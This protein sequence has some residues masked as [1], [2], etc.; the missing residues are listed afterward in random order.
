LQAQEGFKVFSESSDHEISY[1]RRRFVANFAKLGLSSTLLPGV[2]WARLRESKLVTAN[3]DMVKD[4]ARLAGLE[5]TD[6]DYKLIAEDVNKNLSR[7]M[8]MRQTHLDNSVPPPLYFNPVV[9]GMTIDRTKL[10]MR[11]SSTPKVQRPNDLEE[12]AFWPVT[13]L[14]ELI[15]TG[16]VRSTELTEMY[17]RRLRRLNPK[18]NCVVTLTDELARGEARQADAEIAAGRYRGPLHG[19]PYGV[20]D[21]IAAKGYPTTWG[22]APFKNQYFDY[23]ATVID[24]LTAAGAVL[25]AKLSTGELALGD[26][27]FGG[28]TNNPWDP[29]QGSSGSS[30]GSGA[31][32]AAGLV[33]FALGTDTGGSILSPSIVCGIVGLRPTFGRVSRYGVMAAGFSL[34]KVGVMSRTVEDC[35]IVLDVIVGAD[36]KD[37]A[38]PYDV[39]FNWDGTRSIASLRVGFFAAG[40]GREKDADTRTNGLRAIDTLRSLGIEPRP[41]DLPEN[42]VNYFI[43]YAER[44]AG[45]DEFT[46]SDG[47]DLLGVQRIRA[48]HRFARLVPAVEYLQANR[49]RM[50]VM[51]QVAK[52]MSDLDVIVAPF[53]AINQLTASTG[54]PV[55]AVPSG[56]RPN[57]TPTGVTLLGQIYKEAELLAVAKAYQEASGLL[58]KHPDL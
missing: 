55:V 47:D 26:T 12:V 5:F 43:E 3:A 38:V 30:A 48:W 42:D 46:R 41:A 27:W 28:R 2:L 33:G 10:G 24:R 11:V 50:L 56:F 22:A 21:I 23:N 58:G 13:H 19:I 54:H 49:I 14:A 18:L 25:V 51:E 8:V 9:P 45:F 44:A 57:G 16:S 6:D 15:K 35:A 4:A 20:K 40:F 53:E 1:A 34:D 7:Y 36:G 31:A 17:L 39:P 52:V 32:T 37:L 29:S